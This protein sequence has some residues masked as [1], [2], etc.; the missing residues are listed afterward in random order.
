[1]PI[2]S[3]TATDDVG[4]T[5]YRVT[6]SSTAPA[7]GAAGWT[8]SA[9]G[10][11][12]FATA[13]TKTLYAWAK[14]AAGNVSTGRSASTTI[15][16]P[17]SADT[18][19]PTVTALTIAPTSSSLTVPITSLTATDNVGV[20]GYQVTESA[21]APAAGA[22]GWTGSA[23]GSHTFATAGAKTL[24]AWAKDAAGNVSAGRSASTTI[25]LPP[26]ADTVAPTVTA[27]TIAPTSSSLTVPI[28]SLTAT[29]NVGVTGYQVTE[30]AAAPAAGAA[31]W[32]GSAP[33]SHTFATAGAKT[34]YAWA[35]DAAGNVSTGRSATTTVTAPPASDTTAPT[36]SSFAVAPTSSSLSV[37]ITIF[38]ATD[39]V[40]VTGYLVTE[41]ATTPSAGAAGWTA[42]PPASYNA[43]S[44][45]TKT[46]YGWAK[47]A[48]GNVS[49]GKSATTDITLP[50]GTDAEPPTITTF[51]IPA[52]TTSLDVP[53]LALAAS[54]NVGVTGYT[55]TA[56]ST[57]PT[58]LSEDWIPAPPSSY[59]ASAAG[60]LTLYAWAKDAA[61]NVSAAQSATVTINE[62]G[63]LSLWNGTWFQVKISR[64]FD[65]GSSDNDSS[66][67]DSD[68][69]S[70]EVAFMK[71]RSWDP[72][73]LTLQ[74]TLFTSSDKGET[75]LA[76]EVPLY[77]TA[78]GPLRF[79]FWFQYAGE[80]Q[81][82]AAMIGVPDQQSL[83]AAR[84]KSAGIFLARNTDDSDDT[85]DPLVL[86]GKLVPESKVP[87]ELLS[88]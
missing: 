55:V 75:W 8:G 62:P 34:L 18:V 9:P 51:S 6:E 57:A 59:K 61:G 74:T 24:Y 86:S 50:S 17:P 67:D 32:T 78:G 69:G 76:S 68:N 72:V 33:G 44:A 41:S 22:A 25:T 63:D 52:T 15:T 83:S 65:R 7:A 66:D 11:Y 80:F 49:A 54:D 19:A 20:T 60:N 45:G 12:T 14:D 64:H 26:S 71:I 81:F 23:P 2:T 70:A 43:S 58:A 56:S 85:N 46:L 53:I 42:S 84:F 47:D 27:L 10:S 16:L 87:I 77:Y 38:S 28:T 79:L 82:A 31:G 29:D 3:L 37:P 36:V 48:A 4:V 73:Q 13:G 88:K 39:N 21:A 30:S 40:A 5:G 35:K 1:M